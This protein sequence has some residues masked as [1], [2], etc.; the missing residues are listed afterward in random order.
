MDSAFSTFYR[1]EG[2]YYPKFENTQIH[3]SAVSNRLFN[4]H[5]RS[6]LTDSLPTLPTRTYTPTCTTNLGYNSLSMLLGSL[7]SNGYA[8]LFATTRPAFHHFSPPIVTTMPN[9]SIVLDQRIQIPPPPS[10]TYRPAVLCAEPLLSKVFPRRRVGQ[11]PALARKAPVVLSQHI[12]AQYFGM[13]LAEAAARL[14]IC[15]TALKSACRFRII[16]M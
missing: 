4:P 10:T 8:P 5:L 6:T 12:I 9:R 11:K 7:H 2:G 13:P 1:A 15:S 16:M 14:G 3:P